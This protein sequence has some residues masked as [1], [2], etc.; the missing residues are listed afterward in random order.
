MSAAEHGGGEEEEEEEE[1]EGNGGSP[2]AAFGYSSLGDGG[3]EDE[4]EEA[5]TADGD[6]GRARARMARARA[7]QMGLAE[8]MLA[9]EEAA[10]D[11]CL[12]MEGRLGGEAPAQIAEEEEEEEEEDLGC[13]GKD[14][15]GPGA[16]RAGPRPAAQDAEE[17]VAAGGE[18]VRT[19][20]VPAPADVPAARMSGEDVSFIKKAM[21]G[22]ELGYQ[23][24]W[25]SGLKD[26]ALL[27][28]VSRAKGR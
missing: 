9:R 24:E 23:P 16:E 5:E 6:D 12:A 2:P 8:R 15:G 7:M 13:R 19:A 22:L 14:D 20:G 25:A 11:A 3:D 21:Q 26:A 17:E 4:A 18:G 1:E 27:D 10:Y 28:M